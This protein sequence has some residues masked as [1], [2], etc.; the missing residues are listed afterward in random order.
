MF[1]AL[2]KSIMVASYTASLLSEKAMRLF[3]AI[4]KV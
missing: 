4:D 2:L 3:T 1:K